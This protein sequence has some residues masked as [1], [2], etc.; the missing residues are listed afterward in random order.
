MATTDDPL[1]GFEP[2][3]TPIEPPPR[4]QPPR[5]AGYLIGAVLRLALGGFWAYRGVIEGR[6]PLLGV[7]GAFLLLLGGRAVARY[8]RSRRPRA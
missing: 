7:L 8:R 3:R 6:G 5:T 2:P 4:P 1:R